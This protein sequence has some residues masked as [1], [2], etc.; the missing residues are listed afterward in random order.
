LDDQPLP[1][2]SIDKS[3]FEFGYAENLEIQHRSKIDALFYKLNQL[4]R[5]IAEKES[6]YNEIQTNLDFESK[7]HD[8]VRFSQKNRRYYKVELM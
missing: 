6:K 1:S 4:Q 5:D 7:R 3:L 8:K 2:I